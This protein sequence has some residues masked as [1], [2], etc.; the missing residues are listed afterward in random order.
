[1]RLPLSVFLI[2]CLA[3]TSSAQKKSGLTY[4][5]L[6]SLKDTVILKQK[7]ELKKNQLP[8]NG[9]PNAI[10]TKPLPLVFLGNNN[11]GFD[12]YQSPVDNMGILKPDNSFASNMPVAKMETENNISSVPDFSIPPNITDELFEK[13]KQRNSLFTNPKKFKSPGSPHQ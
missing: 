2:L 5:S 6:P 4:A 3:A 13:P 11:K 9:I 8:Y 7:E 10:T 1:M 12:M